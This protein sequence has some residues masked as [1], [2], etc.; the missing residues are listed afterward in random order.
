MARL[1]CAL[2]L[3]NNRPF[4]P[5]IFLMYRLGVVLVSWFLNLV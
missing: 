5:N 4:D 3:F 2:G 1:E